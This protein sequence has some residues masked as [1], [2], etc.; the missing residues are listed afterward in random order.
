MAQDLFLAWD[1]GG[2]TEERQLRHLRMGMTMMGGRKGG[3]DEVHISSVGDFVP[4]RTLAASS[5]LNLQ[6]LMFFHIPLSALERALV[7]V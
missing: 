6:K 5:L 1:T 7:P 2:E 3:D 4:A